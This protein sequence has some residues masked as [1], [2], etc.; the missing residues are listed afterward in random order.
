MPLQLLWGVAPI[1]DSSHQTSRRYCDANTTSVHLHLDATEQLQQ[2]PKVSVQQVNSDRRERVV[3]EADEMAEDLILVV[4]WLSLSLFGVGV[5]AGSLICALSAS[6]SFFIVSGELEVPFHDYLLH[7]GNGSLLLSQ[8]A[9]DRRFPGVLG[10]G[11]AVSFVPDK[12]GGGHQITC[13]KHT[14]VSATTGHAY[15]CCNWSAGILGRAASVTNFLTMA[16]WF[17]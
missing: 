15:L 13:S 5:L 12:F 3:D 2:G 6:V 8:L 1:C 9:L 11:S 16:M 7:G 14:P 10:F 17:Q 4:A